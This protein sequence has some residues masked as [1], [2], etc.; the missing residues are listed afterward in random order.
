MRFP[1]MKSGQRQARA[2]RLKVNR[3]NNTHIIMLIIVVLALVCA[4]YMTPYDPYVVQLGIRL[5]PPSMQHLLGTDD[6]GRDL[7]SRLM[8][9]G[10]NT[11]GTSLLVLLGALSIGIPAGLL[12]GY[13]GG[14]LDRVYKRVTDAFLAFPD[15]IIAIVLSGLMGPGIFNL[16]IAIISVKWIT[17]SRIVRNSVVAEK[18]QEYVTIA[19]LSGLRSYQIWWKHLLP[20]A[21]SHVIVIASLDIGKIILMIASLSYIGLGVQPPEPE[22]GAMLNEGRLYF[23]SSPYLM[24]A[25]GLA[26]M[27]VVLWS[28]MLGD[29]IRDILDIKRSKE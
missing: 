20:H 29:R 9:G 23:H 18:G 5:L 2:N 28:N 26:I 27:L 8:L 25:P 14:W 1:G 17:Y 6:L 11:V 4:P 15:F 16:M 10:R 12:A 7:L 24:I 21:L 22:W 19:R 3:F 13:A